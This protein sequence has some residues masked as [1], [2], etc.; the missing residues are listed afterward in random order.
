MSELFMECEEEDLEPWQVQE[1][2]Q[3]DINDDDDELIFVGELSSANRANGSKQQILGK[4][5]PGRPRKSDNQSNVKTIPMQTVGAAGRLGANQITNVHYINPQPTLGMGQPYQQPIIINN[6]GYLV[7]PQ[8]LQN[9]SAFLATLGKQYPPGTSFTILP[10]NNELKRSYPSDQNDSASKKSR[11]NITG[12]SE[13]GSFKLNCPKCRQLFFN[14]GHM[15][16]HMKA[17]CPHLMECLFPTVVPP[18]STPGKRIMLVKDFYYGRHEGDVYKQGAKTNT[19]FKCQ[20]CLKVL[21]NN[22]R[23]MNHMKHH[24]E[25][26]KQNNESYESHTTCQHCYR[27]YTT[28]FQLQCHIESA[29]TSYESSTNCKI[30]ELAF[31]SEQVLLE[32]MKDNHKPGE[33]PYLCQVCNYRSSFFSDV[34]THFRTVHENTKDLLCPFCLKI[35]RTSSSYMQHYMKH[36]K[37]GIHRCGKCRL[38]FLTYKE[39]VDHKLHFHKTFKKPAALEGLPP[40]TKVTIRASFSGEIAS[41]STPPKS[42]VNAQG[43][44]T[45]TKPPKP[46]ETN[47]LTKKQERLLKDNSALKKL[48]F[49]DG[50]QK[51]VEC[52]VMVTDF[53]AHYPSVLCCGACKY[54]TSCKVSFGNHMIRFHSSHQG[55]YKWINR[56]PVPGLKEMNL[57]CVT[58][59]FQVN[60]SEGHHMTKHLAAEPD[61]VCKFLNE[62]GSPYVPPEWPIMSAASGDW[63]AEEGHSGE[64][65][66]LIDGEGECHQLA[67][68]TEIPDVDLTDESESA[69]ATKVGS[70]AGEPTEGSTGSRPTSPSVA[71]ESDAGVGYLDESSNKL[72]SMSPDV[73]EQAGST[74]EQHIPSESQDDDSPGPVLAAV[75]SLTTDTQAEDYPLPSEFTGGLSGPDFQEDAGLSAETPAEDDSL[76]PDGSGE[77]FY[78]A[79]QESLDL[80]GESRAEDDNPLPPEDNGAP[81]DPDH[82]GEP[83]LSSTGVLADDNQV[84]EAPA[85]KSQDTAAQG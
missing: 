74:S 23:F 11:M 68:A 12:S 9:N 81:P 18:P 85:E 60:A 50:E 5:G 64:D 27:Q 54:R 25:L 26:E 66:I 49:E 72:G 67:D 40:G 2:K 36:Q 76:L 75:C 6:Q 59:D 47:K 35:H 41:Y 80:I 37:K 44:K 24:L 29:H 17:C 8:Q 33:M 84:D 77:P 22:V 28:P 48:S 61:H 78:R 4:K 73:G 69:T 42:T 38:N 62:D 34:E 15:K 3:R 45:K 79:E 56:R 82:Q 14:Q 63:M 7:D 83:E 19:T 57:A 71:Y 39:R 65:L 1:S 20:S 51:C 52:D 46:K 70:A 16:G 58:C 43:T 10:G 32:H 31:E 55:N 21:K 13:N 30:C 53:V